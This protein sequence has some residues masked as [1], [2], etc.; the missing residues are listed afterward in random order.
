[1]PPRAQPRRQHARQRARAQ[2]EKDF[3][4]QLE[5]QAA[6]AGK[7]PIEAEELTKKQRA[8]ENP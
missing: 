3:F 1:M 5:A 2:R 6:A 4:N 7:L 8:R